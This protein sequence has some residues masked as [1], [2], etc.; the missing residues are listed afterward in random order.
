MSHS[1]QKHVVLLHGAGY[2]GGEIVR[3]LLD[4][5]GIT[6]AAV[7]SRTFA[8]E[9]IW[10]PHPNLRSETNLSFA[11]PDDLDIASADAV[12]TAA[13]HGRGH[14]DVTW[15][16]DRGFDGA[17]VDLSADFRYEDPAMYEEWFDY[18]HPAPELLDEFVYG[19][20]ELNAPYPPATRLIA[21]PGC[22]ATGLAL[23]L[24]PIVQHL[25]EPI[26]TVTALTGAS[27]SGATPKRATHFPTREGNV[28][29]YKIFNHQHLPEVLQAI[30]G[31]PDVGFVPVSGPWTRG[32]W[33][34]VQVSLP[35]GVT[36]AAVSAWFTEAYGDAPF[37]RLWADELPELRYAVTTP[38]CDIGWAVDGPH[39]VAGFAI[40]NL[41][42]GAAS[43]AVQN[44]NL[45]LDLPET[46]GLKVSD[47]TE[48][49]A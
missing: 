14:E 25:S 9:P 35:D 16:L 30:G 47:R 24:Q 26:L 13:E 5:P 1:K 18:T 48:S 44:M 42:K 31:N 8:E 34:T 2:V 6:L 7:T 10:T 39:M 38:Y 29:A 33:G 12:L 37:V 28:R 4:H 11:T 36:P 45:V 43:Q 40:D 20:P 21:N 23:T 32:I 49:Y 27:G 46:L 22:F 41:L 3:I 15:L 19:L 17:I